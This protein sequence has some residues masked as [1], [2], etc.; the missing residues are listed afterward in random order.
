MT[1]A[2]VKWLGPLGVVNDPATFDQAVR[3]GWYVIAGVKEAALQP[4]QDYGHYVVA[5][6][7]DFDKD[8][9]PEL[10]IVD[11]YKA[12]DGGSDRYPL[13]Q[14]HTAMAE[15]WDPSVDAIA[16]QIAA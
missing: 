3:D 15:N 6:K 11:S 4:G 10:E 16:F 5:R 2:R 8:G 12:E 7:I 1:S 14:F 9:T 13:A